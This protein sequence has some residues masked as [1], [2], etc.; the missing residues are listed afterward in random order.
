MPFQSSPHVHLPMTVRGL[1][2]VSRRLQRKAPLPKLDDHFKNAAPCYFQNAYKLRQTFA[3][4]FVLPIHNSLCTID[5][6]I[7][8]LIIF[9]VSHLYCNSFYRSPG[10]NRS[11]II[12]PPT[13]TADSVQQLSEPSSV[14]EFPSSRCRSTK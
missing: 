9:K 1:T 7:G 5:S 14:C 13:P 12:R 2:A 10:E 6:L 8:S 4:T 3:E 11:T